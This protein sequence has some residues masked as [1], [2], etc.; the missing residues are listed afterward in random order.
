[1]CFDDEHLEKCERKIN[2]Y[3]NRSIYKMKI[4]GFSNWNQYMINA[5]Y[6]YS[7]DR[8]VLPK[9]ND[10]QEIIL[11]GSISTVSEVN[12]KYQLIN[13]LIYQ[14][15]HLPSGFL[16]NRTA[17]PHH[18]MI[19]HSPKDSMIANRFANRLIDEG[20]SIWIN[21]NSSK[22]FNQI[23]RKI[24][25]SGCVILCL[26]ENYFQD[27]SCEKEAKYADQIGKNL[28]PVKVQYFQPIDWLK[29]IMENKFYF[30]LFGSENNF[31]LEYD[32]LL[33][34]ILSLQISSNG[35]TE[36]QIGF[37]F[38]LTSEQR[39]M[40]Y[41]KKVRK[42]MKVENGKLNEDD[43]ENLLNKT[44]EILKA[45]E[46]QCEK[47]VSKMKDEYRWEIPYYL[48]KFILDTSVF[49]LLIFDYSRT[50]G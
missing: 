17:N 10:Q 12:Q 18:I 38:L 13:A 29:E 39:K 1:M 37:D 35:S 5:F 21:S 20:L 2:N 36:N 15:M 16:S 43:K 49:N 46:N 23:K 42:L 47:Y 9:M 40:K 14:K 3:L 41:D 24:D 28:I 44:K 50:F 31:N 27:E 11:Y 25:K 19:S 32:K 8:C 34:K 26:S 30:Q 33:L 6:K 22:D 48:R 45:K 7:T 4:N